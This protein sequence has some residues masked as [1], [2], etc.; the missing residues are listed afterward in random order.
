M[1]IKTEGF[2][3]PFAITISSDGHIICLTKSPQRRI[4]I[5]F[6]DERVL[7]KKITQI[8]LISATFIEINNKNE[9]VILDNISKT[10]NWYDFDLNKIQF[11]NLPGSSYGALTFDKVSKNLYLSVLDLSLIL[12]INSDNLSTTNF[13]DYSRIKN[14]KNVNSLTIEGNR[15][16]LLDSKQA[17]LFDVAIV[18]REFEYKRYLQ[19]GRGGKGFTRNP[20]D[21]SILNDYIV[22]HDNDNYFL[23]FFDKDLNFIFQVGG[24][25][26][27]EKKFDL[28]IS[29]CAINNEL[30]VCD[31]NNDRII[32]LNAE[33]RK[34]N[35]IVEDR[36]ING[37]LSRPSGVTVGYD[38]RIYIADRSNGVIQQFD[39]NL[40]FIEIM[41]VNGVQLDRPSSIVVFKNNGNKYIAIIERK[42][43]CN[44]SLNIYELSEDGKT[45]YFFKKFND[46]ISLNDP[47]DMT[48]S[49]TGFIYV[50]DTLNRRILKVG[51]DGQMAGQINMA[52]ISN[53]NR[54]LVKTVYVRED[55]NI[56]TA[57][58]DECIVYQ[59][60]S[61]LQIKNKIDF[62]SMKKEI[63]VLR[64]VYA[65]KN[66]LLLC[67]RGKN[68]VLI[69]DYQ[70]VIL[71]T[72][73]CKKQTGLDWNHPV[74][75]CAT[76]N[77][78]IFIADK[79]NDRVIKFDNNIDLITHKTKEFD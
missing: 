53:N 38:K 3:R 31:Q 20:T 25:G 26:K 5:F 1:Y 46:D 71:K 48:I 58:F 9:L 54:I 70:G 40:N 77:G 15:F 74:N 33:S 6:N 24:K 35:T 56:F 10:L 45:L 59:F 19:F 28:P 32:I 34:V 11:L 43:G 41:D 78:S 23:Q 7:S 65:T 37:Q 16:I 42:S 44:S 12:Q 60:D 8:G 2:R 21:V 30:Y 36:F 14:C 75:I 66:Y 50:A 64:A 76:E 27:N 73:D 13:L 67:V 69:A 63:Q 49:S 52:E 72:V 29:G 47:Q 4:Y 22:V 55:N 17:A 18:N 79:E 62:S 68:E 61:N 51:I 57:D 39:E